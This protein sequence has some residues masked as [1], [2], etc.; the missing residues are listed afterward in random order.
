M[1]ALFNLPIS[2]IVT[3]LNQKWKI[4]QK[5]NILKNYRV[6][7]ESGDLSPIFSDG[8]LGDERWLCWNENKYRY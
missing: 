4:F 2:K 7:E 8:P 6:K 3:I 5:E 1:Y